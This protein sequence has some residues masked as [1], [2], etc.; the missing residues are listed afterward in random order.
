M[1][2]PNPLSSK[3]RKTTSVKGIA[4]KG[5]ILARKSLPTKGAASRKSLP[6]KSVPTKAART[7][8]PAGLV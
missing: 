5:P 3:G 2:R 6:A 7:D 8:A 1:T 4:G